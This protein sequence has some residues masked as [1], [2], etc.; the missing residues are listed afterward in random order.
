MDINLEGLSLVDEDVEG[1]VFA[2]E[3]AAFAREE[4][5]SVKGQIW[6]CVSL[7]DS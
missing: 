3:G 7:G 1:G 2:R 5:G 4:R 6:I